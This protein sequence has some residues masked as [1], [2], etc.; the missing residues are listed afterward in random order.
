MD[1]I[2]QL[3]IRCAMVIYEFER[4]LGRYVRERGADV[5]S[6]A[7]GRE[8]LQRAG[9]VAPNDKQ[10]TTSLVLENS[11]IAEAIQLA[12]LAADDSAHAP[13]FQRLR[14]I[15]EVLEL[16]DIRNAVSHPNRPFADCYWYRCCALATDPAID[17]LGL[18]EVSAAFRGALAGELKEPPD[19]WLLK[20]RWSIPTTLP[21][22][23]EHSVTGLIGRTRDV[24]KLKKELRNQ[25][26]NLI[27][28]VAR[29]GVGKT[30]LVSQVLSDFCMSPESVQ[31]TDAVAFVSLKQERLTSEGIELLSAPQTMEELRRELVGALEQIYD[32]EATELDE[33]IAATA[34]KRTWLFIDNLETLLRDKPTEFQDFCDRLPVAWKV[35]VTSRIPLDGAKNIPLSPLDESGAAALARSYFTTKGS[36]SPGIDILDQIVTSCDRNPLAIRLTI[37]YYLAGRDLSS[38]LQTTHDDVAAFSFSN[39]LEVLSP[40]ANDVLEAL[41]VLEQPTRSKLCDALGVDLDMVS[42]AISELSRTSLIVRSEHDQGEVYELGTSVR[43]LLRLSPRNLKVRNSMLEWLRRSEAAVSAAMRAQNERKLSPLD[44]F[45]IP[46]ETSAS[47]IGL[48][49]DLARAAARDDFRALASIE[50]KLRQQIDNHGPTAFLHRLHAKV[51]LELD[52]G[53]F[54]ERGLRTAIQLDPLDPAPKLMLAGMLV[55]SNRWQDS[56]MLAKELIDGNWGSD[57]TDDDPN[58]SKL[59]GI[60]LSALSFQSKLSE[61]F[62]LTQDWKGK[63]SLSTTFGV[64]RA[65]AYRLLADSEHRKG[66]GSERVWKLLTQS[67]A[68][69]DQLLTNQGLSRSISSVL[70][71]LVGDVAF[72]IRKPAFELPQGELAAKLR[73]FFIRYNVEIRETKAE[74]ADISRIEE[75]LR[76][77]NNDGRNVAEGSITSNVASK[78]QELASKGYTIATVSNVP[79]GDIFPNYI[80]AKDAENTPYFL[81][82]TCFEDGNW[83]R[84]VHFERGA[85][86]AIRHEQDPARSARRA[87]EIIYIA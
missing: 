12:A 45:F 27:S 11:Y 69:C 43:D 32:V 7:V 19:N 4:S 55:R 8:V 87:T 50:V 78:I 47:S 62:D 51:L 57:E 53:I 82:Y 17:S 29:G 59:W 31:Y 61:I 42:L 75:S 81:H 10:L 80:F 20:P 70:R 68:I 15:C 67:L 23:F 36:A 77:Q 35:I 83:N 9:I 58:V 72:Y 66:V 84:W 33:A 52:D 46:Q 63:A 60:Y 26:N 34:E 39:L 41:F 24:D 5:A 85:R 74:R 65:T 76:V 21:V 54:A 1:E 79:K 86:V 48:A 28:V 13:H 2:S 14:S 3:R 22:A 64:G 30:S 25:R 44:V 38:S 56:E 40:T 6:S 73:A 18:F 16:F 71:R 49:K 37:D